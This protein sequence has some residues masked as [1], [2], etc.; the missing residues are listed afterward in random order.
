[1]YI[2]IYSVLCTYTRAYM[3]IYT[4]TCIYIYDIGYVV[5]YNSSYIMLVSWSQ[6]NSDNDVGD[7]LTNI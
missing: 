6:W 4:Y 5:Q 2:Q 7:T 3:Y 1:M